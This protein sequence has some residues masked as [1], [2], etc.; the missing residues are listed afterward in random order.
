MLLS[1]GSHSEKITYGMIPTRWCSGTGETRG[2]EMTMGWEQWGM[3]SRPRTVGGQRKY[4]VW[5][6]DGGHRYVL[7]LP[8]PMEGTTQ[9]WAVVWIMGFGGDAMSVQAHRSQQKP[10]SS[11]GVGNKGIAGVGAG[12]MWEIFVPS[13]QFCCEPKTALMRS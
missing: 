1:E 13:T 7:C 3:I 10:R 11:V 8:K 6:C 12:D 2:S 5:D 9:E 4:S